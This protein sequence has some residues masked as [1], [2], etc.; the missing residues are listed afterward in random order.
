MN[1]TKVNN[2]AFIVGEV[3]GEI[4]SPILNENVK[5]GS[6]IY[7][8]TVKV[9]RLSESADYIPVSV[10][11]YFLRKHN[12]N[13]GEIVSLK[14]QFRSRNLAKGNN[15]SRL[16]LY[17]YARDIMSSEELE[18]YGSKTTNCVNLTGFLCKSPIFRTTPF[19]R[20]IC[21]ILLAVNRELPNKPGKTVTDY[22]PLILWGKDCR[23]LQ[24][25]QCDTG[26]KLA[27]SGRIQ[28]RIYEKMLEDGKKEER[29]AYEVSCN[30][31]EVLSVVRA[32]ERESSAI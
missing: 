30:N 28:S 26:T 20:E 3:V 7:S 9:G 23:T 32:Q 16:I 21:D 12:I 11:E 2:E 14:G 17:F 15:K 27:I 19:K 22:I 8:F 29:T 18:K 24:E 1:N 6:A 25:N 10:N 31:L 13:P 4:Y 5:P